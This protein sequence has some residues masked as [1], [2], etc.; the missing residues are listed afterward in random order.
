MSL[1]ILIGQF[2]GTGHDLL[3]TSMVLLLSWMGDGAVWLSLLVHLE[4]PQRPLYC[5]WLLPVL[6]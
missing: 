5:Q 2:E 4:I 3:M 6:L 1:S